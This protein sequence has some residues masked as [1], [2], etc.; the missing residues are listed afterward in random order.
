MKTLVALLFSCGI[1]SGAALSGEITVLDLEWFPASDLPRSAKTGSAIASWSREFAA[2]PA[3]F[4]FLDLNGDGKLEILVA[5]SDFPSSGR[6]FILLS[7]MRNGKW[8]KIAEFR[9]APIFSRQND[10]GAFS[11]LLIYSRSAGTMYQV[12]LK[13]TGKSYRLKSS[14]AVPQVIYTENLHC[15]WQNLNLMMT[16]K[17][18]QSCEH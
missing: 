9:G 17:V 5:D 12:H 13:F 10:A 15:L 7:M 18:I 8:M 1:F 16:H 3:K 6:A 11:D 4:S 2:T 14:N